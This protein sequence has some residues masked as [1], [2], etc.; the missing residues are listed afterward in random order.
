MVH[1]GDVDACRPGALLMFTGRNSWSSLVRNSALRID[2]AQLRQA[3]DVVDLGAADQAADRL[4]EEQVALQVRGQR[5][6]R[7]IAGP[8][9][10]VK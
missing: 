1:V 3:L 4:G 2:V 8:V 7:T 10:A 6:P 5:S 9:A